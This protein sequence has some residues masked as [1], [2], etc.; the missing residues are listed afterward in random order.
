MV[1][2]PLMKALNE[3]QTKNMNKEKFELFVEGS[4]YQSEGEMN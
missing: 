2:A 1:K 4:R 3:K